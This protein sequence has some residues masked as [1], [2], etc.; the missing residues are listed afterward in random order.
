MGAET[1]VALASASKA[2]APAALDATYPTDRALLQLIDK[3]STMV[4]DK[5]DKPSRTPTQE[6]VIAADAAAVTVVEGRTAEIVEPPPKPHVTSASLH[7]WRYGHDYWVEFIFEGENVDVLNQAYGGSHRYES[8]PRAAVELGAHLHAWGVMTTGLG[9]S[10]VEHEDPKREPQTASLDTTIGSIGD[11]GIEIDFG[12]A[13][14][15]QGMGEVDGHTCYYRSRGRGWQFMVW[16]KGVTEHQINKHGAEP[17]FE[18]DEDP[19][20]F[21]DGG[22]LHRDESIANIRRAVTKFREAKP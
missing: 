6:V 17:I 10:F 20:A 21:P 1:A 4:T 8:I 7:S 18:Y 15:V 16:A 3:E 22:W 14:P 19:Y 9:I 13:C 5:Q 11:D 2:M 12:G